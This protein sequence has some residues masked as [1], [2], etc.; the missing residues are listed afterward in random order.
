M[1][2]AVLGDVM[3]GRGVAPLVRE[4]PPAWLWGDVLDVLEQA[5]LRIANLECCISARGEPWVPKVF[6]FRAPPEAVEVLRAARIDAVS[7]ANNHVLDFGY[8]AFADTIEHLD[9][10]GIVHAGAGRDLDEARAPRPLAGG[11]VALVA[12]TDNQPDWAAGP[13]RPGTNH[14]EVGDP[15]LERQV[16]AARGRATPLVVSAHWGPNMR[17]RPP[18]AHRDYARRAVEAGAGIWHGHSAHIP[19]GAEWVRGPDGWSIVLYDTGDV[20]DDYAV[21]PELRNDL[22]LL[23]VVHWLEAVTRVEARPLA[24]GFG[25]VH[26]ATGADHRWMADRFTELCA[27]LGTEVREQDGVLL[28]DPPA[29]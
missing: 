8:D 14:L 17:P 2:V 29:A 15:D 23:F 3:L 5:H 10:A 27:D 1:R 28:L 13:G 11:R 9:Q 25:R 7:L 12:W 22:S 18:E 19:Q 26:L 20:I 24:L 21:D 16:A 4:R 6:H